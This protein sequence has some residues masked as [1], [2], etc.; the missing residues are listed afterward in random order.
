[1]LTLEAPLGQEL[2]RGRGEG[3]KVVGRDAGGL[4]LLLFL[5]VCVW[6]GG[7]VEHSNGL[8]RPPAAAIIMRSD[9]S[10]TI[11]PNANQQRHR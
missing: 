4:V 10:T 7:E 1:M 9:G 8:D 6:V 2:G 3:L 5:G 11:H